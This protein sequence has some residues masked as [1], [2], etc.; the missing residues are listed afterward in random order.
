MRNFLT[1]A[2]TLSLLAIGCSS[3]PGDLKEPP[4]LKVTSPARSLVQ[5]GAG[6]ITVTGTVTPNLDGTPV[7]KVL[8]NNVQATL[9]PDG[10]FQASIQIGEGA[11]F[12]ETVARDQEGGQA[13]DT[14][15][16]QAGN[17][18]PAGS[19]INNAVTAAMSTDAF[20]KI[21]AAAGPLIKGMNIG[22]MLAPMQP[23]Q[24]SGDS[25]GQPDCLYEQVFINDVKF[26]DISI[27][28]IPVQG[29]LSFRAQIDGLDVP[30]QARYAV[31]C[32][33]GSTNIRVTADRVVVSGTLLV[34]PNGMKGFST[35]LVD[36]TVDLTNF[37]FNASGIPGT[38]VNMIDMRNAIQGIV[39]K[40]AE[41]AM[42]PMMNTAM[43]ALAGPKQLDVMGK[44]MNVEV[45]PSDISFDPS[46]ALVT[47]NMKM[48]IGG[49]ES[50]NFIYTENGTPSFDPGNGFQL[51]L[52]DDL[53]N[54]MMAEAHSLGL[55]NLSM[56]AAGGTFDETAISM[57]MPPMI[58]ADPADG[59]MRIMLGDMIATFKNRGTP[60]AKAAINATIDLKIESA[61]NGY[62]VALKLGEP[63]IKFT[64][65]D[66]IANATRL[67]D[68][69][70]EKASETCLKAQISGISKLLVNIPLPSVAGLQMRNLTIGS[71][72]GYVMVKGSF[73]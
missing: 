15:A 30:G 66:D 62:A 24:H 26:S 28:L 11:S 6:Q 44:Q 61:G 14:R 58:S 70:L 31:A 52:A 43:G 42:E 48:L 50:A 57:S 49:S 40:G 72:S 51:G 21:S 16:V 19:N 65:L 45:E 60:L 33:D 36:Q 34:S 54:E 8:V 35:N 41:L 38:I 27:S 71:D 53:A 56:P 17:L 55:L 29:G 39:A 5:S 73:E 12:I 64:V 69:D 1:I 59:Q 46:G 68:A 3:A 7:E 2:P 10:T 25:N 23:M 4:I 13:T 9:N 47:M 67:E 63:K 22:A 37:Q 18:M 32:V 20:T